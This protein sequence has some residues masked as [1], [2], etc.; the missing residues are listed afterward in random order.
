MSSSHAARFADRRSHFPV[1]T[2]PRVE[3][4]GHADTNNL[5]PSALYLILDWK[6]QRAAGSDPATPAIRRIA[7]SFEAATHRIAADLCAAAG[8]DQQLGLLLAKWGFPLPTASAILAFL[9]PDKFTITTACA[10]APRSVA[11]TDPAA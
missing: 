5:D 1:R 2:A 8:S 4:R 11:S 7:G 6:A 3:R 10:C 9:Y